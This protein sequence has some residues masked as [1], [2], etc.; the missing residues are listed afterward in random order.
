MT[1]ETL[2][3][4][5]VFGQSTPDLAATG[6]DPPPGMT[7][8]IRGDFDG[9]SMVTIADLPSFVAVLADPA[10]AALVE[11]CAADM[12]GS[13]TPDGIDIRLFVTAVLGW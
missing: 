11:R 6:N 2:V 10:A 5:N 7:T 9:D 13:G 8:C 12:D 3:E 4:E 1:V